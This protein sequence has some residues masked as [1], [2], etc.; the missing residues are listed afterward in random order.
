[1]EKVQ[2]EFSVK[3]HVPKS[4]VEGVKSNE[5]AIT[6]QRDSVLQCREKLESIYSELVRT[7]KSLSVTVP[8]KQHKL[9]IGPKGLNANAV[10]EKYACMVQ[11][12]HVT[13]DS[14]QI[15]ILGPEKMLKTALAEILENVPF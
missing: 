2:E 15:S 8:K 5:F 12:P 3:I 9:I 4:D 7:T 6:G 1:M 11:I 10:F 14:D 13:E